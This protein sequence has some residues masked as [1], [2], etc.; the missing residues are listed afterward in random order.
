MSM[1]IEGRGE[2]TSCECVVPSVQAKL[3]LLAEALPEVERKKVNA[4]E[5]VV[6]ALLP[7]RPR[8][9]AS[10]ASPDTLTCNA[11]ITC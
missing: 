8:V 7:V 3:K 1:P 10:A 11:V 6:Q 5:M 9:E 4:M 2:A